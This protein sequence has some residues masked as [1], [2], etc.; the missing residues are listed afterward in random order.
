MDLEPRL[1][2]QPAPDLSLAQGTRTVALDGDGLQ[3]VARHV[4]PL[5]SKGFGDVLR[6]ADGDFHGATLHDHLE[7]VSKGEFPHCRDAPWGV[8]RATP[9]VLCRRPRRGQAVADWIALSASE[10]PHGA[11]LQRMASRGDFRD[12]L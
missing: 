2:P 3:G 5:I 10:T 11:S 6:Q 9:S 7:G 4:S 8:S 1:Q 12:P